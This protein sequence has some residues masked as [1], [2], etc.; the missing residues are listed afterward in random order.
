[1]KISVVTPVYNEAEVISLF[2]DEITN[3]LNT[4][5]FDW[6]LILVVDP[7]TD[8]TEKIIKSKNQG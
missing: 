5:D 2:I 8:G 1:M 7:S 4:I 3:Q 6:E